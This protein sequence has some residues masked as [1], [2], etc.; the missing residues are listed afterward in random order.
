MS[1]NFN[2]SNSQSET[3]RSEFKREALARLKERSFWLDQ[4]RDDWTRKCEAIAPLMSAGPC[5]SYA[6]K[7]DSSMSS[8]PARKRSFDGYVTTEAA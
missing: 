1:W 8:E 4:P 6:S 3:A 2:K 5:G 7:L